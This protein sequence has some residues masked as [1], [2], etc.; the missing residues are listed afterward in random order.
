MV[1]HPLPQGL[2]YRSDNR[3][4]LWMLLY[5]RFYMILFHS[6]SFT[7]SQSLAILDRDY[8]GP[9]GFGNIT[10]SNGVPGVS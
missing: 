8:V 9:P 5:G 7:A 1:L 10:S 3:K 2:Y 6:A 4:Q